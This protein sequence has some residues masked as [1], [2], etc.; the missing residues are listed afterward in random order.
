MADTKRVPIDKL[1]PG[2]YVLELDQP[3]HKTPFLRHRFLIK[4]MQ[5]IERLR[6]SAVREVVIDLAQSRDQD[7]RSDRPVEA[8]S[9]TA[10]MEALASE[11]R[12]SGRVS[13]AGSPRA[14]SHADLDQAREVRKQAIT[15]VQR[16]FEGIGT[17][18]PLDRP[19]LH[20]V[21][22]GVMDQLLGNQP[23]L[24]T[25]V[26][27]QQIQRFDDNLFA[28]VVDVCVLS[29]VVG[30]D[31]GLDRRQLEELGMGALLHDVG[32]LRLPRNL[33]RRVGAHSAQESKLWEQHPQLGVALLSQTGELPE[34]VRRIVTEHH[35]RLDGSGFPQG[36][37]GGQLSVVGQIVGLVDAYDRLVSGRGGRPPVPPSLAVREVFE[38]SLTGRFDRVLVERLVQS[39][40]VYPVGSLVKLN[41]GERGVVIALHAEQR[42]KPVLRMVSDPQGREYPDPPVVDMAVEDPSSPERVIIQALD[43][44]LEQVRVE[45]FLSE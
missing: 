36:L 15:S 22:N 45:S 43:S 40:G 17:G 26:F 3:W 4:D 5:Q 29:L 41:T 39:L 12:V 10:Q 1:K 11:V 8:P 25:Q 23:A 16:I 19:A 27:L 32:H 31:Q 2:M 24:V 20:E 14:P 30:R 21:V 34:M 37:K 6:Q 44:N 42:L 7:G 9:Q 38:F 28:H 18:V 33:L 13:R 35:E